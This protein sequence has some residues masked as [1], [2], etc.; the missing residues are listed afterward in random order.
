MENAPL[1]EGDAQTRYG[2]LGVLVSG[3]GRYYSMSWFNLSV[4]PLFLILSVIGV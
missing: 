3:L 4:S 1:P 2:T